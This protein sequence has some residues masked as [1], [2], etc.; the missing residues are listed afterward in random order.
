MLHILYYVSPAHF[1]VKFSCIKHDVRVLAFLNTFHRLLFIFI[2]IF[3][4]KSFYFINIFS[5]ISVSEM[6][7]IFELTS[8]FSFHFFFCF[9]QCFIFNNFVYFFWVFFLQFNALYKQQDKTKQDKK[10]KQQKHTL[11]FECFKT[12]YTLCCTNILSML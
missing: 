7:A 5:I 4:I 6:M 9:F 12:N 10:N 3:K 11:L 8:C 2:I 1:A